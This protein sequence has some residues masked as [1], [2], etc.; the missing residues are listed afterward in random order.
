[1]RR[2]RPVG[3]HE[4]SGRRS[5]LAPEHLLDRD[6]QRADP[7]A[8]RVMDGIGN[9]SRHSGDGELADTSRAE[10]RHGV[11]LPHEQHVDLAQGALLRGA[12][13]ASPR[14]GRGPS[15]GWSSPRRRRLGSPGRRAPRGTRRRRDRARARAR[16]EALRPAATALQEG[17][18]PRAGEAAQVRRPK[19]ARHAWA[20][21]RSTWP[22]SWPSRRASSLR[23]IVQSGKLERPD[24]AQRSSYSS[25]RRNQTPLSLRPLGARSSH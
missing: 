15:A 10:R 22:R 9:R 5:R 11:G 1:M 17:P 6:R 2:A 16:S 25:W 20:S 19:P 13:T 24:P 3:G 4:G 14:H 12:R 23:S 7:R 21:A 8:R 18:R